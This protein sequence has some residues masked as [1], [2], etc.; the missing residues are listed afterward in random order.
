AT[1]SEA[2]DVIYNTVGCADVARKP[3]LSYKLGNALVKATPMSLDSDADWEGCLED[4]RQA[5]KLKKGALIPVHILVTDQYLA[6]LLVKL[7]KGK[8]KAPAK[9]RG[10][11]KVQILD[12]DHAQSD[13]DDFDEGLGPMEDEGKFLEQLQSQ[14]G[15]CQ[16]CGPTKACKITI[17]GSHHKLSNNQLSAWAKALTL[18]MHAVTLKTPPRDVKGQS[19]FSMFFKSAG[20]AT[21]AMVPAIAGAPLQAPFGPYMGM[22]PYAF[23]PW[24]MP[25]PMGHP[26][27][28]HQPTT[29]VAPTPFPGVDCPS[30]A[31]SSTLAAAFLSSDPPEMGALNPYP[32]I[33]D[34]LSKLHEHAP[35]RGLLGYI[36]T[37]E[38]MDLYNIDEIFQLGKAEDLVRVTAASSSQVTLG[39]AGHILAEVKAAMKRVDREKK[40]F[41]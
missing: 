9:V 7:G 3:D 32:E 21:A 31:S 8:N 34:F 11:T 39:N 5:E 23:M 12:L 17:D 38:D 6:S 2:L 4:V 25:G 27:A 10:K 28:S 29:P 18:G 15:H 36:A 19:L 16:L 41:A 1:F 35:R 26:N 30:H 22:N 37:F 13:D 20:P 24:G 33:H 14:Y 40:S